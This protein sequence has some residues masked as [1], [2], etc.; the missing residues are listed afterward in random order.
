MT[1]Q[2]ID[3]QRH[4][5]PASST[6]PA[7]DKHLDDPP[8][9]SGAAATTAIDADA[10]APYHRRALAGRWAEVLRAAAARRG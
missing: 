8:A 5:S 7:T 1:L 3:F 10:I 4:I 2:L 6:S 9:Q